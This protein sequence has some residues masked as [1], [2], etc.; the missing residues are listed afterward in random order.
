MNS[1]L[2]IS[3]ARCHALS[4]LLCIVLCIAAVELT[5]AT[6]PIIPF[7]AKLTDS[8]GK[9]IDSPKTVTFRLYTQIIGGSSVWSEVQ[10]NV[11]ISRGILSVNL[12]AYQDLGTVDGDEFWVGIAVDTDAEM[13]PRLKL[14]GYA[15]SSIGTGSQTPAGA[16]IAYAGATAPNGW[17][18]CDGSAVGRNAFPKLFAATGALYG[19]GDGTS[20]FNLPNFKGRIPVGYDANQVEFNGLGKIG[21][22]KTHQLTISE[23]P[24]HTHGIV[25]NDTT[26]GTDGDVPR[27]D[28]GAKITSTRETTSTGGSQP[29]DID[30]AS[31]YRRYAAYFM[32]FA[33]K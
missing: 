8:Q 4:P 17:M 15:A 23:M 30:P 12:G 2:L 5:H 22:N 11:P 27:A 21:G 16:I 20:T 3:S 7:S 13:T 18:F 32:C 10:T 28:S 26:V 19:G 24:A 31:K 25:M 9:V 14:P 29:H 33:P 1:A 6:Q